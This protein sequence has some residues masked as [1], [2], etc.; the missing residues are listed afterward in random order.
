MRVWGCM[1]RRGACLPPSPSHAPHQILSLNHSWYQFPCHHL[2]QDNSNENCHQTNS[3]HYT[4]LLFYFY[5]GTSEKI[6][7]WLDWSVMNQKTYP[8]TTRVC[9]TP[10]DAHHMDGCMHAHTVN[11]NMNNCLKKDKVFLQLN[12]N[13]RLQSQ[14]PHHHLWLIPQTLPSSS[15]HFSLC[16]ICCL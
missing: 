7:I 12:W 9:S 15:L 5:C 3:L 16:R 2:L 4:T 11:A 6:E 8:Q 14:L 1:L 10:G 13:P